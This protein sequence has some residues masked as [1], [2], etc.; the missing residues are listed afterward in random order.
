MYTDEN[1]ILQFSDLKTTKKVGQ[2][3]IFDLH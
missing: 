1:N 2:M 3:A